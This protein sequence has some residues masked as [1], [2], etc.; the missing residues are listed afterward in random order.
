[1]PDTLTANAL[2]EPAILALSRKVA[3][4]VTGAKNELG[5]REGYPP[6]DVEIHLTDGTV[7]CGCEPYVKGHPRNPMTFDE[8][9]RKFRRCAELSALPIAS[10]AL[11]AFRD[12]VANLDSVEDV[13]AIP[14]YLVGKEEEKR[15]CA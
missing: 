10:D 1:L 12:C 6:V 11:D 2:A 4:T 13:R 3:L 9:G 8:V 14:R 5:K 7:C 15:P